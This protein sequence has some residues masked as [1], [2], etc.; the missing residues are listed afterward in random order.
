MREVRDAVNAPPHFL[1]IYS[2]GSDDVDVTS[3]TRPAAGMRNVAAS[4]MPRIRDA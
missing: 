1:V 2:L 4:I 3:E